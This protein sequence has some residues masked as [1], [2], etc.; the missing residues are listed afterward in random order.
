M[1]M[2]MGV[3]AYSAGLFH[4]MTHAYF[5]A[6]MFLG[7]G[8]VI[9]GM[10]EVVGHDPDVA[11]DMRVMGGLRK[12][13]PITAITFSLVLWRLVVFLPLLVSGQRMRFL[14]LLSEP[15]LHFGRSA[16]RRRGS[17]LS[18]CSVCTS[19]PLKVIFAVLIRISWQWS[20]PKILLA[21]LKQKMDMVIIMPA[22]RMN[23]QLR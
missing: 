6:M 22:S 21:K 4:L 20:K 8:S 2:G 13:M 7:S 23:L 11:Q 12:Y 1:V 15:I 9:H 5:K 3:G 17:L 14:L 10:E 16:L 19:L 18:I